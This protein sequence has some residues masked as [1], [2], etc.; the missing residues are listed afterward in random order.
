[1]VSAGSRR[2]TSNVIRSKRPSQCSS[3]STCACS[4]AWR[5]PTFCSRGSSGPSS[6]PR[7][8]LSGSFEVSETVLSNCTQA[9]F[10]GLRVGGTAGDE[11]LVV[12]GGFDDPAC[13]D[14]RVQLC[15]QELDDGQLGLRDEPDVLYLPH[16][17]QQ[18]RAQALECLAMPGR[19]CQ[20]VYFIRIACEIV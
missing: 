3:A 19:A 18:S 4:G 7:L 20:I 16:P 5:G 11:L 9:R 17:A 12:E 14:L 8:G 1:M 13:A 6:A 10:D 15:L 2:E